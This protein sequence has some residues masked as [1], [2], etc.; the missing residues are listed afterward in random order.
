ME[1][2]GTKMEEIIE[3]MD[4]EKDFRCCDE[5][6]AKVHKAKNIGINSFLECLD[7]K[8]TKVSILLAF[9][10]WTFLSLSTLDLYR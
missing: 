7:K 8:S 3:G 9:W 1:E 10:I 5:N 6:F 2:L 4:C